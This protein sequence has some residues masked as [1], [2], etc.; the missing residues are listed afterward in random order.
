MNDMIDDDDFIT[1]KCK[2][3]LVSDD[4]RGTVC[5]FLF[6]YRSASVDFR[7]VRNHSGSWH[8]VAEIL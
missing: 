7:P 8:F 4:G 3:R 1:E 5:S 6:T 2:Q